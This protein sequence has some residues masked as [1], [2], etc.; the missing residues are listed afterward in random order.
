MAIRLKDDFGVADAVY[1]WDVNRLVELDEDDKKATR[2]DFAQY[3]RKGETQSVEVKEL[4]GKKVAEIPNVFLQ[5]ARDIV[6]YSVIQTIYSEDDVPDKCK[7]E[8]CGDAYIY[9]ETIS[10]KQIHVIDRNRPSDYI[11]TQT[12]VINLEWMKKWVKKQIKLS[13]LRG[14]L[15]SEQDIDAM[16]P[17]DKEM[18]NG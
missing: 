14:T 4:C 2:V 12:E 3:N 8:C 16:F 15:A 18:V 17:T 1:Q 9:T 10:S 6:C 5:D 7:C 13:K 11:Y